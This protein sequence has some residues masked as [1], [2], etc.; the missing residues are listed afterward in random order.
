MLSARPSSRRGKSGAQRRKAPRYETPSLPAFNFGEV[1]DISSTGMRVRRPGKPIV[2]PGTIEKFVLI[3]GFGPFSLQGKVVWVRKTFPFSRTYT[4]GVQFLN[5]DSV[6]KERLRH[7]GEYGF[8][9]GPPPESVEDRAKRKILAAVEIEDLYPILGVA[10]SASPHE[11]GKAYRTLVK[12]FHPDV[13]KEPDAE[14]RL[15]R[16]TKAY[17]VLRD[18]ELRRKYDEMRAGAAAITP[19]AAQPSAKRAA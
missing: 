9:N 16:V 17:K 11:L 8:D 1:V 12:R 6:T 4:F 7:I 15:S 5:L 3:A 13:C 10:P 14:E 19:P 2:S 18:P